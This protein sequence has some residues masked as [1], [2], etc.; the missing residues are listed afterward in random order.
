MVN[1]SKSKG[2]A[3]ETAVTRYLLEN[4]I[5]ARREVL[6]GNKDHGDVHIRAAAGRLIVLEVKAYKTHASLAQI[7]GWLDDADIEGINAEADASALV[8][9]RPGSAKPAN[10]MTYMRHDEFAWLAYGLTVP[11][12]SDWV[13][14]TLA[15]FAGWVRAA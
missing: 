10:W 2:T 8:V 12:T 1:P 5:Q 11:P 9:K 3:A 4:G 7:A 13:A 6:H 14:M 15:S